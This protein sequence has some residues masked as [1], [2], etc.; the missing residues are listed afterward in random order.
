MSFTFGLVHQG[1]NWI[2]TL[3]TFNT[4]WNCLLRKKKY[5]VWN[6]LELLYVCSR[7]VVMPTIFGIN[8]CA[9]YR[10][11]RLEKTYFFYL[12]LPYYVF[13]ITIITRAR[14][15]FL[16]LFSL[17]LFFLFSSAFEQEKRIKH[18]KYAI[19]TSTPF[20]VVFGFRFVCMLR[21]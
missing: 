14:S 15:F 8:L 2:C 12:S 4:K 11:I 7:F 13:I 17:L 5:I 9:A 6:E 21:A 19:H 20:F 10:I 16:L 3:T 18:I 1:P